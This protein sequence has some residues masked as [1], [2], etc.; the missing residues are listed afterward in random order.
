[1]SKR[2]L[3]AEKLGRKAF[4]SGLT[5][6]PVLDTE[7]VE[8][9]KIVDAAGESVLSQLDAWLRSWTTENLKPDS[10]WTERKSS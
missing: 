1:M 5:C 10:E 6:V 3:H 2:I 9:L 7:F 4:H 8:H